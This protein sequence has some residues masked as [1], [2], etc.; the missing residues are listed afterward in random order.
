MIG[1]PDIDEHAIQQIADRVVQMLRDELA[2][3]ATRID[4][5]NVVLHALSV[6]EVAKRLGVTRSTVY[7][8]WREWGGY[9]LG[10]GDKAAIRFDPQRLLQHI[11]KEPHTDSRDRDQ[12]PKARRSR[13]AKSVL[14]GEARLPTELLR[15][16]EDPL[17]SPDRPH[18]VRRLSRS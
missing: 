7:T 12:A 2:N 13:R 4:N 3:L 5:H 14:R 10:P 11:S 8:H 15:R 6:D 1:A 18:A 17:D 9:K 16:L